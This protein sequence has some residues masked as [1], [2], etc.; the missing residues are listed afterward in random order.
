MIFMQKNMNSTWHLTMSQQRAEE[1]T[2][3]EDITQI[4]RK[5]YE[6]NVLLAMCKK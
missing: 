6:A 5:L 1:V 3:K 2:R 4:A